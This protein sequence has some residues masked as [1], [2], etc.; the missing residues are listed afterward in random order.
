MDGGRARFGGAT[1]TIVTI[2]ERVCGRRQAVLA[3]LCGAR[4]ALRPLPGDALLWG[5]LRARR[6]VVARQNLPPAG[7]GRVM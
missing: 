6:V 4:R 5:R 3:V 1:A 7:R 2:A